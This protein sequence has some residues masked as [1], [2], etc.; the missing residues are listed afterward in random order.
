[1]N[2]NRDFMAMHIFKPKPPTAKFAQR[3]FEPVPHQRTL[4]RPNRY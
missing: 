2:Q 4:S 1:M 3:A